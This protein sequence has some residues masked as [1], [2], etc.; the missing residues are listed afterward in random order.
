MPSECHPD[1]TNSLAPAAYYPYWSISICIPNIITFLLKLNLFRSMDSIDRIVA[2][3]PED[4]MIAID[5]QRA[6]TTSCNLYNLV[7]LA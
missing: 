5:Y 3:K 2:S 4:L 6:F 7:F 1:H